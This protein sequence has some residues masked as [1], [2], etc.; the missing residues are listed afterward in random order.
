V[1]ERADVVRVEDQA[2]GLEQQ[3]SDAADHQIV[4]DLAIRH[5]TRAVGVAVVEVQ[6]GRA[7]PAVAATIARPD[8]RRGAGDDRPAGFLDPRL[9]EIRVSAGGIGIGP[10]SGARRGHRDVGQRRRR[11]LLRARRADRQGAHGNDSETG[12]STQDNR[13]LGL[14]PVTR[15]FLELFAF[16]YAVGNRLCSRWQVGFA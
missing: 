11:A 12:E 8:P 3:P 13:H 2:V 16:L 9:A 4:G 6:H 15:A 1:A 10:G 5:E 14:S 7:A